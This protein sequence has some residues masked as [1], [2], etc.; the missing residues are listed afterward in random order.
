MDFAVP[1]DNRLKFKESEKIRKYP[2]VPKFV[3]PEGDGSLGRWN[4]PQET[5][6]TS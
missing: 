3:E 2:I 4:S 1:E 5:E 6:E